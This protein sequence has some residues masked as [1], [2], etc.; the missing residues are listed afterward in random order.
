MAATMPGPNVRPDHAIT[1][2]GADS[3]LT[4]EQRALDDRLEQIRLRFQVHQT[5]WNEI[6]TEA[7][8]DDKFI[9]GNHWPE[10]IRKEREEDRRPILTYNL[11]PSFTRQITNRVR[12]NR[13][14]VKV[15]PTESNR[16][17]NPQ[18]ANVQGT[19]DY[20][21]ADVYSG[22]I[23]N[24][25]HTSRAEQAYDTALKHAVDHGF[26]FF[27]LMN[28]W[29]RVD[30]FVQELIIHRVRNSYTIYLDP[31][32]QEADF[33]DMQ[34]AFMFKNIKKTT[35]DAKY[36]DAIHTE[37][38][39]TG[40]GSSYDGWYD[41][42]MLRLAQYFWIDWKDDEVLQLS[43][44]KVVYYSTVKDVLDE[45]EEKE[46]IY[47]VTD[48]DGEEMRKAVKR[49]IC[50]WQKM[51]AKDVLEG[52][53]ELP[54]PAVPIFP[55][56]GEE[57]IV[58]GRTRYESAI[59]HAKD[60]Q[61]SY[62]YWRTA[63]AETVAL[64]PR[65]PWI[66]TEKQFAGHEDLYENANTRNLPYL[67]YNP[68]ERAQGPPA[69]N[70]PT[71][72]AAAELANAGQDAVDMQTIIGLHEA[73]LGAESNEK[74]GKAISERRE[75]GFTSTYQF[76]DNLARAQEQCGRLMVE[77]I[78]KL[79]DTQRI[80][81]IRLPD[82][83]DDFVEINQTIKDDDSDRTILVHD[84][85]Y[86]KYDVIMETGPSYATQRQEAADLQM[87]LLKVLGP[88]RA[89]NIVHLIVKNLGVPGSDE[90]S[91]VLRKML[92]DALKSEDEKL[93][94]LPKGVTMDEDSGQLVKDGEP[95]QPPPTLEQQLMQKQ[96]E[97]DELKANAE[98]ATAEAK[99]ATAEA[100]KVQA[101][102]KIA[103]ADAKVRE[104]ENQVGE[105]EGKIQEGPDSGQLMTEIEQLIKRVME[106]HNVSPNAHREA[107]AEQ[108]AD[109]VVE[110]LKRTK[111]YVDRAQ[112]KVA[113]TQPAEKP[114]ASAPAVVVARPQ[115]VVVQLPRAKRIRIDKIEHKGEGGRISAAE[116]I[117]LED[118]RPENPDNVTIEGDQDPRRIEVDVGDAG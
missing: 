63:A 107:T 86:G 78:P 22:I 37:F 70:F 8:E 95:W 2:E 26:G 48:D 90:V 71:N 69:R 105:L 74:S 29:S 30:P 85:A 43:N 77:A 17:P 1:V 41:K 20:A 103:E 11:L 38:A 55:V 97:I 57:I 62:N 68:D 53:L 3:E 27:Y 52:P 80:V 115:N 89:A 40:M 12:E 25:E 23:K 36:P 98:K 111:A 45:L 112:A 75:Q 79:Y 114:A 15:I 21:L 54:F 58:D 5:F 10:E 16:G 94:D 113:P 110:A 39:N 117:V 42:D 96:Q 6:H 59:R 4:T 83:T 13:S 65:A 82:D 106:E 60:P 108:I 32:A 51:T 99:M 19:R 56:F 9:A 93:A 102:A 109:A 67:P 18:I 92:P 73:S 84:I 104:L 35:F 91:A 46:A 34:D 7:L 47:I 116:V 76:P 24:I 31:D 100:D 61:K 50:M 81:R 87:D 49:P 14:Q 33:R 44:G 72:V 64:A 101:E 66:G 118:V 88:D 28:E